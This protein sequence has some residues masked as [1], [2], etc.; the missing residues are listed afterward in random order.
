MAVIDPW[1]LFLWTFRRNEKDVIHLYDSLSDVMRLATGGDM[2]NF[3]YWTMDTKEPLEAQ[4]KLCSIFLEYAKLKKEQCIADVG[5]GFSAPAFYWIQKI[6]GITLNCININSQQL[7]YSSKISKNKTNK[8]I[9]FIN[10][11]ATRLPFGNSCIDRV[12]ALE[13]SQHFKPIENFFAES[14]R[15]L[16]ND[17]LLV[18]ALPV[19]SN[20]IIFPL[21]RLGLVAFTWSSEH[22]PLSKIHDKLLQHNFEIVDSER[23]GKFVYPPLAD[24]Y[25]KNRSIIKQKITEKYPSYVESILAKSINKMHSLSENNIIDYVL[26]SCK[27]IEKR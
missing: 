25:F 15:V 3:G 20:E 10:S 4:T 22:Y 12:L 5:S 27:P 26:L 16:K 11:S 7:S 18:L 17:G 24:Y 19:L 14:Y 9:N 13:S 21:S 1:K 8:P 2:L 23:I 6:A